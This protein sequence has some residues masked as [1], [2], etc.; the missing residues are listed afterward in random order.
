MVVASRRGPGGP[1]CG[2]MAGS[3]CFAGCFELRQYLRGRWQRGGVH[4][5]TAQLPTRN[6]SCAPCHSPT[7][8]IRPLSPSPLSAPAA[9][10][11]AAAGPLDCAVALAD[12]AGSCRRSERGLACEEEEG[13]ARQWARMGSESV[14][15]SEQSDNHP[16]GTDMPEVQALLLVADNFAGSRMRCRGE[17]ARCSVAT[18]SLEDTACCGKC[19]IPSRSL[20]E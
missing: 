2:R 14:A 9:A 8:P 7:S 11:A 13:S 20:A 17:V 10:A 3:A 15:G 1:T 16:A 6:P 12:A 4:T 19:T 5:L 18:C